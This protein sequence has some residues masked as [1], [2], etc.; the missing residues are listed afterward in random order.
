MVYET[1]NYFN[2]NIVWF[3]HCNLHT[4]THTHDTIHK[5]E[6]VGFEQTHT[7][8][9]KLLNKSLHLSNAH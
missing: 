9:H 1:R 5:L 7:H 3:R 2:A 8:I 6:L 4:Y